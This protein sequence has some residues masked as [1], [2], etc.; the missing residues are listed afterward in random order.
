MRMHAAAVVTE[1]R[2][3]HESDGLSVLDSNVFHDVLVEHH[4]VGGF[5]HGVEAEVYFRLARRGDLVVV[6]FDGQAAVLH[7]HDHL[8]AKILI[9]I[10]RWNGEIPFLEARTVAQVALFPTGIPSAFFGVDKIVT[11]VLALFEADVVE[12]EELG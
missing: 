8:A 2:L 11:A 10:R 6:A 7:G 1:D 12:Y 5:D 3:R 4:A 9:V